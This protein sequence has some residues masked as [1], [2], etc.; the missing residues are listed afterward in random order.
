VTW[1]VT[2]ETVNILLKGN[3][4]V[5][6]TNNRGGK[7]IGTRC[8][9]FQQHDFGAQGTPCL[10]DL[11]FWNPNRYVVTA[12]INPYHSHAWHGFQWMKAWPYH[13]PA[14]F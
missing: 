2:I 12:V 4:I 11:K 3:V 14:R 5:L 6:H 7:K 10:F 1:F 13:Q 8:C 9:Q